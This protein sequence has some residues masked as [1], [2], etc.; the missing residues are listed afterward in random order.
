MKWSA[1]LAALALAVPPGPASAGGAAGSVVGP[2]VD[3]AAVDRFVADYAEAAAYRGVAVA[4]TRGDQVVH[5]A[6]YGRDSSGA[7]VTG[8]TPMPVASVSKSFTA[9]AVLRLVERGEVVLDAPVRDYLPDFRLA[10]PR[11]GR[12][13]V[14]HL[15]EHT[16]G[17]TDRTLREKSLPQPGSP[18]DAVVRARGAALAADPGTEHHYTNTNYH[19]AARLVEVVAGEPFAEHLRRHVLEPAGMRATTS[20]TLTPR[21]LPPDVREGHVHAYGASIPAAE[22]ERF[23]AGS[24]GVITTAEDMARWLVV[25]STGGRGPV[26]PGGVE[27]MHTP[28]DPRWTYG[29]GWETRGGRV[30]HS[31]IWFT[32]TAGQLLLPSGYGIAVLA[33]SGVAPGNEGTGQLEDGL[34]A[35]VEAG[36]APTA[37]SPRLLI[38]LVLAARTALSLVLGV[39]ALRRTRAW[40][41]R[42]GHRPLRLAPRLVPLAV[43][44]ALPDL[45]GLLVGGGRDLTHV[46]L[47]CYSVALVVWALVPSA[48]NAAV[49]AT[50]LVA[51]RRAARVPAG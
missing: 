8:T 27:A 29:M 26:S 46:Q 42:S 7:A 3:L 17:I 32:D 21:D 43:L 25:Q 31:G 16:S 49:L 14:R 10:D 11:G 12:I 28:S 47:A 22:P 34:A 23:V 38:D 1:V 40:V 18:A 13:T 45:L 50:R 9:L 41:R 33:N 2:G 44:V 48:L 20:I 4:I 36:A 39:R 51:P 6:G 5:V 15:L 37:S 35:I 19:L 24:D 30:R